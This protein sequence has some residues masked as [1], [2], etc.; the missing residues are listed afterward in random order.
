M[1]IATVSLLYAGNYIRTHEVLEGKT[2]AKACGI[3]LKKVQDGDSVS[4]VIVPNFVLQ[5]CTKDHIDQI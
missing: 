2:P 4:I 3:E 5:Y 1:Q